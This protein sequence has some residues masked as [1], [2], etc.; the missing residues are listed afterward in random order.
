MLL[1]L[2][3]ALPSG[4]GIAIGAPCLVTCSSKLV[5]GGSKL[6]CGS[7]RCAL[8]CHLHFKGWYPH[9]QMQQIFSLILWGVPKQ[10]TIDIM[11][12]LYHSLK[13][14]GTL[15]PGWNALLLSDTLLQLMHPNLHSRSLETLPEAPSN[16][17]SFCWCTG[18][19][20]C[21]DGDGSHGDSGDIDKRD[22]DLINSENN[23]A[24]Y[25]TYYVN[26]SDYS[27]MHDG[28]IVDGCCVNVDCNICDSDISSGY[29]TWIT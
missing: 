26:N 11:V 16:Y 10:I 1:Q 14:S 15:R 24:D 25:S 29:S 17:Y 7:P 4:H 20:N 22:V 12:I 23:D 18:Y 19:C 6:L 5:V 13:N 9:F 28:H 27:N 8:S 3:S 2:S 21:D